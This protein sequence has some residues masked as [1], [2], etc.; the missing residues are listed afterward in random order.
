M[1]KFSNSSFIY[2]SRLIG[3]IPDTNFGKKELEYYY[4]IGP[5]LNKV[6]GQFDLEFNNNKIS[7]FSDD[8]VAAFGMKKN[9]ALF[10]QLQQLMPDV[11]AIG[12]CNVVKNIKNA[13]QVA[14]NLALDL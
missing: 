6:S 4:Y 9:D 14:F 1:K 7:V 3:L 13:N 11:I 12:D 10:R 2:L 5:K 8:V